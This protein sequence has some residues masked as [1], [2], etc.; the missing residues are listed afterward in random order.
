MVKPNTSSAWYLELILSFFIHI[1]KLGTNRN[2]VSIYFKSRVSRV[3]PVCT[4]ILQEQP[5]KTYTAC[6]IK[7]AWLMSRMSTKHPSTSTRHGARPDLL[8]YGL[9]NDKIQTK[10]SWILKLSTARAFVYA[11]LRDSEASFYLSR[12]VIEIKWRR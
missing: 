8:L 11:Y 3:H 6:K 12:V 9:I 7:T 4:N 2:P 10:S 1:I 5:T